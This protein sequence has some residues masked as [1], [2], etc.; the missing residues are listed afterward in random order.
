[1][2]CCRDFKII[3]DVC[4]RYVWL[5]KYFVCFSWYF[6]LNWAFFPIFGSPWLRSV[7]LEFEFELIEC[8]CDYKLMIKISEEKEFKLNMKMRCTK[9]R[10]KNPNKVIKKICNRIW[11]IVCQCGSETE[12][13]RIKRKIEPGF[14]TQPKKT[15]KML[16]VAYHL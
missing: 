3:K 11:D 1:M 6:F 10:G 15:F 7:L 13:M 2:V 9:C 8:K 14:A 4:S 12:S 5:Y 16:F